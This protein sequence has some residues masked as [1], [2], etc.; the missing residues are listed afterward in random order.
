MVFVEYESENELLNA[1]FLLPFEGKLLQVRW[2]WPI[3]EVLNKGA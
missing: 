2:R 3:E 1:T